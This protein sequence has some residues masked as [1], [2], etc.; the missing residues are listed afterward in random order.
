MKQFTDIIGESRKWERDNTEWWADTQTTKPFFF[1]AL[2]SLL[3]LNPCSLLSKQDR[4]ISGET[5]GLRREEITKW[6]DLTET[7]DWVGTR[8]VKKGKVEK[9]KTDS[10][11]SGHKWIEGWEEEEWQEREGEDPRRLAL[12]IIYQVWLVNFLRA[13]Q[14]DL[15]AVRWVIL[16]PPG[17]KTLPF[18]PLHLLTA[19]QVHIPRPRK[20]ASARTLRSIK[21]FFCESFTSICSILAFHWCPTQV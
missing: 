17:L 7:K 19:A 11:I 14:A 6:M 8:G 12:C 10:Q 15:S 2:V 3:H 20:E 1:F 5:S 13:L 16:P 21:S 4:G 9:L 18:R